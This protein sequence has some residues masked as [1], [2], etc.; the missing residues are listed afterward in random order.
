VTELAALLRRRNA[1]PG[2]EAAIDLELRRSF[3]AEKALYISDM[4]GFSRISKQYGIIHFLA[5]IQRMQDLCLPVVAQN[6]GELVKTEA[7]NIFAVFD[8]VED[9]V[10]TAL[11]VQR[12]TRELNQALAEEHQV[13]LSIGLGWGKVLLIEYHDMF[14]DELNITSKLGEDLAERGETLLTPAAH[15]RLPANYVRCDERVHEISGMKVTCHS[16]RL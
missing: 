16:V 8:C 5:L 15:A 4:S 9:A 7:D 1:E 14:G 13:H 6:Q 3:L 12:R 10:R 2:Q 11:F